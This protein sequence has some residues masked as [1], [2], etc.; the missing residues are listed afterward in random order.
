ML[1]PIGRRLRREREA[2]RIGVREMARRIRVSPSFV[3]QIELGRANPSVGT[4]YAMV[5]ELSLSLD[6]LM[7]Q[8]SRDARG[9][10]GGGEAAP[11][12]PPSD[13][14]YG[15]VQRQDSRSSIGLP[16]V[17]WERLTAQDD[18]L[19]DFLYVTYQPGGESCPRDQLIRH[20]GQEY[21][22]V[23][24]GRLELQVGFKVHGLEA[25][26]SVAFDSTEPHRLSN[27]GNQISRSIWLVVGRR[28]DPRAVV[29]EGNA[30]AA[31]G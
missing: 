29:A 8:P 14:P 11:A 12:P 1:E 7:T 21:G 13:G 16:G 22:L 19:A 3:S 30:A 28:A 23:L 17:V 15:L 20:G 24:E 4:L 27:P 25:G 26:D 18:G 2:R 9:A 6:D 31:N 5:S 10:S